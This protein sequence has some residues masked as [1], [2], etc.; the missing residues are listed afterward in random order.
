MSRVELRERRVERKSDM[1]GQ[2]LGECCERSV[3]LEVR[4]GSQGAIT[5]RPGGIADEQSR[6]RSLL[7]AEPLASG[8]P[9]ERAIEREMVWV[10]RL[11]AAAAAVASH[12]L[13]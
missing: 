11:E 5:Q 13:A 1:A 4:P 6:V 8:A 9:T 2:C 3:L 7:H 12:V 10:Q